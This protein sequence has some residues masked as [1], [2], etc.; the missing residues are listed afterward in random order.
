MKSRYKKLI[1][2]ACCL[3]VVFSFALSAAADEADE[4]QTVDLSNVYELAYEN[5]ANAK[6]ADLN[7]KAFYEGLEDLQDSIDAA[8]AMMEMP[9][10]VGEYGSQLL[11]QLIPL[12]VSREGR[13]ST[14]LGIESAKKQAALGG[15]S[16]LVAYYG[17][18]AQQDGLAASGQ[19]LARSLSSAE[20]MFSL[21]MVTADN[22][23]ELERSQ[24]QL[25]ATMQ[26]L[27]NA[28][29]T[30]RSNLALYIGEKEDTMEISAFEGTSGKRRIRY[31]PRSITT[32]T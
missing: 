26:Q 15:Q 14:E 22:V 5:N 17:L 24:E 20:V 7:L 6:I 3:T 27:S 25:E 23:N 32:R 4:K 12:Q 1:S 18:L 21:G 13:Q 19:K 2:V 8:W 28:T 10:E 16:M 11:A 9:G 30:L 31:S 29:A